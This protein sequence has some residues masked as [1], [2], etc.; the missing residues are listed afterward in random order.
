M[1]GRK[2]GDAPMDLSSK[3]TSDLR[4]LLHDPER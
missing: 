2:Q 3:W 4:E 1:L